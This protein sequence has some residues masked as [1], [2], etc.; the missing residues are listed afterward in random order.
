MLRLLITVL[1]ILGS[2][3]AAYCSGDAE[4]L[5]LKREALHRDY[6]KLLEGH[7]GSPLLELPNEVLVPLF[8]DYL[9]AH[10]V[11][12][13]DSTCKRMRDIF[14]QTARLHFIASTIAPVLQN[15]SSPDHV[16]IEYATRY[17]GW[18]TAEG[19]P[20]LAANYGSIPTLLRC[21][22]F[23]QIFDESF[24]EARRQINS[25][26]LHLTELELSINCLRA[27]PAEIMGLKLLTQLGIRQR[28]RYA[29]PF[30]FGTHP[31]LSEIRISA[32][33]LPPQ[34]GGLK[35]LKKLDSCLNTLVRIPAACLGIGLV[36]LD[37]SLNQITEL[38]PEI[39][40]LSK[41]ERL[42][43]GSNKLRT[44]PTT[45]GQLE[46]LDWLVLES[47][48]LVELPV[49]FFRL[50]KLR[51]LNLGNNGLTVCSNLI[52]GLEGLETLDLNDNKIEDL[53]ETLGQCRKLKYLNFRHNFIATL[54]ASL[55]ELRELTHLV[56]SNN[57]IRVL[58]QEIVKLTGLQ[59]LLF[60]KN[61]LSTLPT[62]IT[63]LTSIC[64][65]AIFEK[66]PRLQTF[67]ATD[68]PDAIA[69]NQWLA[70]VGEWSGAVHRGFHCTVSAGGSGR[71]FK[72]GVQ[73]H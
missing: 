1:L 46:A 48:E 5:K 63:Q 22:R 2:S 43:V 64:Y 9:Q 56:G 19:E 42:S 69:I 51:Y 21:G 4:E 29:L 70:A 26:P 57:Q 60:S 40:L 30:D 24:A 72:L 14:E 16:S 15:P 11:L 27:I 18:D 7:V 66:N 47:N 41:L 8:S 71:G 6:L 20:W 39:G 65:G 35:A 38:P 67:L 49:E 50:K 62:Q 32:K 23:W 17:F 37:I 10:D 36:K 28:G 68:A 3:Q 55:G 44:L 45:I 13:L 54:P 33:S 25:S 59:Q 12:Q 61:Q 58:P 53:P 52:S 31:C 34:I 73:L